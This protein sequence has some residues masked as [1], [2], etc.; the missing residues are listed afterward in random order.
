VGASVDW[1]HAKKRAE[2]LKRLTSLAVRQQQIILKHTL[3]R[4]YFEASTMEAFTS[5]ILCVLVAILLYILQ[6]K[7][8]NYPPGKYLSHQRC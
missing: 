2:A 7:P 4:T 5:A 8:K 3:L 6:R 1:A